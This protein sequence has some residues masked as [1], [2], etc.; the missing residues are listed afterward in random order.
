[1]GLAVSAC[2]EPAPEPQPAESPAST[3]P[4][5]DPATTE[6][7]PDE[8]VIDDEVP[9]EPAVLLLEPG[10]GNPGPLVERTAGSPE[11]RLVVQLK[12]TE[13]HKK[14]L[15][16]PVV[17]LAGDATLQSIDDSG[18]HYLWTPTSTTVLA[19]GDGVDPEFLTAFEAALS[20]G[21]APRTVPLATD[22][23]DVVG[24]FGWPPASSNPHASEIATALKLALSHLAI[25]V[26]SL[27]MS[28]GA[29]WEV[30]RRVDL[31]G[32][33]AWQILSCTAKKIEGRQLEVAATVR[34]LG[35]EGEPHAKNP[36]GLTTVASISGRGRLRARYDLL[37]ALP[38][39][40]Q[41][42]GKLEIKT[43][44]DEKAQRWGFELRVDEDYGA[45]SD[46]R[47]MLKGDLA[48][49]SLVRGIVAPGTKAWFNK[50]R[51]AVSPEGD[52][53]FG[54][55]RD[56]PPR[57]LLSFSF[58]DAPTERHIL[59][60]ADREF[61]PEAIDG[62][63][64]EMVE[65]DRK[66]RKALA[67]SKVK[68]KRLRNEASKIAYYRE[69]FRWP[70]KGKLTSTYGRKRTLNGVDKGYHWGVDLAAPVG[71]KVRA[72]AAGVVIL[73]EKDVPL[74]G[75][76]LILDHGHG[77][78]SSFLH[79]DTLKAA[80]GDVVKA[81]QVIATSGNTGRSTGPHLD[82]R[83]NLFDTRIDPMM[84][85]GPPP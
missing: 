4:N 18:S 27:S 71:R 24:D 77:L 79:L 52:F 74:S 43:D 3:D 38:I 41:L 21:E 7:E 53:L 37:T 12:I 20:V 31:F 23:W 50:R 59:H 63:P 55:G 15:H 1:L 54:F 5:H 66:T 61:E 46:P 39:D 68:I 36:L 44:A 83:M 62:L 19:R 51:L 80:E 2:S 8:I 35:I 78:S 69:G 45:R 14:R 25:P 82:W 47:V 73:A 26:P 17:R 16:L 10:K 57:A 84:V 28:H 40:M 85:V 65:L 72:P 49:G 34:Y 58:A 75:N 67:R 48:Q 64:P 30:H 9:L 11:Q 70:M 81:G 42:T 60:I 56:A 32:I 29:T 33:P 22:R 76:L 6:T 13:G